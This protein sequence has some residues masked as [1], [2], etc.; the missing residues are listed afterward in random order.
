MKLLTKGS[1]MINLSYERL[2]RISLSE[3]PYRGSTNRFPIYGRRHNTKYFLAE[4]EN[5]ETIFKVMY[6]WQYAQK[7]ITAEE[8]VEF[9]KDGKSVYH[10][11]VANTY[12][13]WHRI[14]CEMGVVRPDNTFEFTATG[15]GY[16]QGA[17]GFL[18]DTSYGYF[19]ND[20]RRGGMVFSSGPRLGFY[21][22]HKG[23]RVDIK[24][25]KPTKPITIVGKA[26]DRKA[27]KKLMAKHQDFFKIAETMCKAMTLESWLDTAKTI[28]LE[29]TNGG[30][31]SLTTPKVDY[32]LRL[33]ESMKSS[34][35]L[36]AVVLYALGM[37]INGFRWKIKN[38]ASWHH[39]R[40]AIET[41]GAMRARL[42]KQIYKENEDTFKTVTYE[43]GK[44][45]PPSIWG[46]TLMVDGVEVEQYGHG[47]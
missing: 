9:G 31:E 27:S 30:A 46:Y 39:H 4:E 5:G 38:P 36:D 16:Y 19:H 47:V 29:H 18:S 24:T 44:V 28:Y 25:M 8:Y 26:V 23:M 33:A 40:T 12:A 13:L 34:A 22:I 43:M 20:S 15:G 42:C 32:F 11:T 37:D 35:P 10:D 41:F 45:Y 17:R 14:P 6:G 1:K 2:K 3:K 7:P 21:P